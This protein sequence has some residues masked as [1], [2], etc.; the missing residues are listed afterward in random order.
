MIV[1]ITTRG[2]GRTLRS[3]SRRTFGFPTP[4]VVLDRYERLLG[5][6]R[7]PKATYIFADLERLAPWELR[8]AADFFR[9]LN[10]AGLRCLN[11]PARAMSRVELLRSLRAAGI[12]PF[13]AMRAD[14]LP[15]PAR[16]PVFLRFEM[17]HNTPLPGLL[18]NQAELDATLLNLRATSVPLR[19]VVVVEHCAEPYSDG[20]WHKW[21]TFRVGPSLSVDHIAVDSNWCVKYG[22]WEKLTDAAISE[23]YEAIK[24]NRFASDLKPAFDIAGIDFGRADHAK[25]GGR[26]I[27]YEIN[28]NPFIGPYVPD[29]RPLRRETQTLARQRFAIALAAIDTPDSGTVP[30]PATEPLEL[31]RQAWRFG[32]LGPRRP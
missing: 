21:G 15:R 2:H 13:D 5:A 9:V 3:L 10:E 26:T 11:D 22:V 23:E 24:S 32:W 19:G 14:E 16:F 28:T 20:L 18:G 7:V 30:V 29:P 25:V 8:I 12:N 1:Y 31:Q 4:R 27:V 6:R 17:D